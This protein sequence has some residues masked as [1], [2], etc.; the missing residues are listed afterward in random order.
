MRD[1]YAEAHKDLRHGSIR[2]G[3]HRLV[4]VRILRGLMVQ[5]NAEEA[6]NEAIDRSCEVDGSPPD[7]S[8]H[9]QEWADAKQRFAAHT[10]RRVP[11]A[12]RN[13]SV[14]DTHDHEMDREWLQDT[15]REA[16]GRQDADTR[17]HPFSRAQCFPHMSQRAYWSTEA[18]RA[19]YSE[20]RGGRVG[21]A[22]DPEHPV[23]S[24]YCRDLEAAVAAEMQQW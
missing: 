21:N 18:L 14:L 17:L 12:T 22:E 7:S 4:N 13:V 11:R 24:D 3:L 19:A 8:L 15:S 6:W 1:D 16:T 23:V 2:R 10:G 5:L 9:A 20:L